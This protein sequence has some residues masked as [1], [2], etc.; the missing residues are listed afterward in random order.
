MERLAAD[1]S[2]KT[3]LTRSG[4]REI[5]VMRRQQQV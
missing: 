5:L 1:A 2:I 4:R 3:F